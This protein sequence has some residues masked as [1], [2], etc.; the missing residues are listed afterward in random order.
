[1]SNKSHFFRQSS[2]GGGEP[3]IATFRTTTANESITLPYA[4]NGT[5][6]GTIDWGDGT[7]VANIYA[8]RTHTYINSGDYDVE[9]LGACENWN[10]RYNE[11]S[12]KNKIIDIKQWG[13]GFRLGDDNGYFFQCQNLDITALDVLSLSGT[14][15]MR[16]AFFQT[17]SMTFNSSINS[18]DWSNVNNMFSM[19][20]NADL[21]NSPLTFDT[22]NVTT[23]SG[24]FQYMNVFNSELSQ[25]DTSSVTDFRACFR[26]NLAFNQDI[27]A[28]DFSSLSV[29]NGLENF[30]LYKT[31]A[32]YDATYYDNLLIKWASSPS[33]GGLQ[34][35]IIN[36]IDMG[37]IKY[38][39]NGA[40][41][42]A[43]ILANNKAQ[44]IND[45]GQI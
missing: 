11:T 5:Y 19:F 24:T 16:H 23:F 43:S 17:Y 42:R 8:N 20:E 35:N 45:G 15:T 41:A 2:G 21:F 38:T 44:I 13:S 33:V 22:S 4:S 10:F 28:W 34:P 39:A 29:S 40:S 25:L 32:N 26:G 14:T 37:T 1:M 30:M 12:S 7:V 6:S 31:S 27:S 9:I 18:W 3:F 36:A